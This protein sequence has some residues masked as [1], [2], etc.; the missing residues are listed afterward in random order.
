MIGHTSPRYD[1]CQ[2]CRSERCR[3]FAGGCIADISRR[4]RRVWR[5][6]DYGRSLRGVVGSV[7]SPMSARDPATPCGLPPHFAKSGGGRHPR[8][9][10]FRVAR[11]TVSSVVRRFCYNL[12]VM[13]I[14]RAISRRHVR[15]R[16]R[17]GD[18]LASWTG[19]SYAHDAA[20]C[21]TRIARGGGTLDLAWNFAVQH[22]GCPR[23]A[24]LTKVQ[25]SRC[26]ASADLCF[27]P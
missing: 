3:T 17:A 5:R 8:L 14:C 23:G 27:R 20:G 7:T 25:V 2:E 16:S 18:R 4:R 19:G 22:S 15:R 26:T 9:L 12:A 1:T 10:C 6:S 11:N 24:P 13:R 21:V